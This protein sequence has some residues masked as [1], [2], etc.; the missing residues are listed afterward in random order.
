MAKNLAGKNIIARQMQQN[1]A[2]SGAL[3]EKNAVMR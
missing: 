1:V 2:F 3:T